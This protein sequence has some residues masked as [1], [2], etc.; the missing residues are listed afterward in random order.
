M[1]RHC[2]NRYTCVYKVD[3]DI[4]VNDNGCV[5]AS[6]SQLSIQSSLVCSDMYFMTMHSF[7]Y[8]EYFS[9]VKVQHFPLIEIYFKWLIII[10]MMMCIKPTQFHYHN[11]EFCYMIF[12]SFKIAVID[13]MEHM[14]MMTAVLCVEWISQV[15][16]Y[17][18]FT[19]I[20]LFI[21]T[22]KYKSYWDKILLL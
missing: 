17:I 22:I 21:Y 3:T 10:E 5:W 6:I 8:R 9:A 16:N 4:V 19:I 13:P 7:V 20:W 2:L 18:T 14:H 12:Q 1:W 11:W 15:T